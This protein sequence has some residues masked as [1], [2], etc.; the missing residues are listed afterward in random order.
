M[1]V[2]KE[3]IDEVLEHKLE[4]QALE[5]RNRDERDNNRVLFLDTTFEDKHTESGVEK[6]KSESITLAALLK[7]RAEM[8][9]TIEALRLENEQ[10]KRIVN[11]N[12]PTEPAKHRVLLEI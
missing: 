7:E 1:K 9:K 2:S 6:P 3:L 5:Y 4:R 12:H 11:G 8:L 10:L